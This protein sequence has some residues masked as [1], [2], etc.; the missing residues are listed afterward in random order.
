MRANS[1]T[2]DCTDEAS[3]VEI[4]STPVEARLDAMASPLEMNSSVMVVRIDSADTYHVTAARGTRTSTRKTTILTRSRR[5]S[6]GGSDGHSICC[7]P[8]GDAFWRAMRIS[9]GSGADG[10]GP[11]GDGD[12]VVALH[13]GEIDAVE[14]L[15][16]LRPEAERRPD[17]KVEAVEGLER[18]AQ[19]RAGGIGSRP[20]QRLDDHLG[21]H[22]AFE[23]DE[24]VAL[25]QVAAI[26]Q[27][28]RQRGVVLVDEGAVLGHSRQ[29]EIVV[30]RHH[31]GIDERAR[32][33]A[34][35]SSTRLD[36]EGKHGVGA[37]EGEVGD[38]HRPTPVPCRAHE[39]A[40]SLIGPRAQDDVA[41]RLAQHGD[42]GSH[43]LLEL[44]SPDVGRFPGDPG[45][46]R[47]EG[48]LGGVGPAPPVGVDLI[49]DPELARAEPPEAFYERGDL[50]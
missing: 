11:I 5:R 1:S 46:S 24:A 6:R 28:L 29:R 19:A 38:G 23:A 50:L 26:A 16:T 32:V 36:E 35:R 47:G 42:G 43:V 27:R 9:C 13:P 14:P 12:P 39:G 33:V 15:V 8:S 34:T 48:A 3:R 44:R 45:P 17:A 7:C 22:E 21:I 4:R 30:A 31:L 37:H 49:E 25:G 10:R 18:L 20:T 41:A 2:S 40:T